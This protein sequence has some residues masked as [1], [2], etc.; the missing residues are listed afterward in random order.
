[1]FRSI[2]SSVLL[3]CLLLLSSC[4]GNSSVTGLTVFVTDAPLDTALSVNIGISGVK[5]TGPSGTYDFPLPSTAVPDFYQLQGGTETALIGGARLPAGNYNAVSLDL[6]ADTAGDVSSLT[7]KDGSIHTIYIPSGEPTTVTVPVD[8]TIVDG[9]STN[10]TIDL[11]LRKSLIPDPAD[12]T[13]YILRPVLRA[14]NN[15]DEGY[16]SGLVDSSLVASGCPASVYVY[17]GDVTPTDVQINAIA[18]TVQPFSSA[19]IGF[20]TSTGK[21][22]FTAAYLPPGEY[23]VAFTCQ[24]NLDQPETADTIAFTSVIHASVL[25][26]TTTIVNLD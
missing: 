13:K 22:N 15:D 6:S 19:L 3:C 1:M 10:I 4:Y 16:I 8:F 12:P 5:V 21:Y 18:G 25:K 24:A 14:V 9:K 20:N 26:K 17:Q 11:D 23:T 2:L 7:L